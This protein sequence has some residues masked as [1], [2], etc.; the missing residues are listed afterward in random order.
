ME[1][2]K[3]QTERFNRI[4]IDLSRNAFEVESNEETIQTLAGW[5][6]WIKINIM[7]G[8]SKKNSNYTG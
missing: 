4:G 3:E 1:E 5:V 8:E 7:N 2:N 6:Q